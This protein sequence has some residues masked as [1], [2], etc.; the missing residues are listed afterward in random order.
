M[1]SSICL[2]T[3]ALFAKMRDCHLAY[4]NSSFIPNSLIA[5]PQIMHLPS[6]KYNCD[7]AKKKNPTNY[8]GGDIASFD[9]N[10][11]HSRLQTSLKS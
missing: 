2:L 9:K 4:N 7:T 1:Y 6:V 3:V 10:I 11:Y 5:T 8:N